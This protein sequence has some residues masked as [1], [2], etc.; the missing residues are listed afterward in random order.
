MDCV[1]Q[2]QPGISHQNHPDYALLLALGEEHLKPR[3]ATYILKPSSLS[4]LQSAPRPSRD[5]FRVK[6]LGHS[7]SLDMANV[8]RHAGTRAPDCIHQLQS[9]TGTFPSRILMAGDF[10]LCSRLWEPGASNTAEAQLFADWTQDNDLALCNTP[11]FPTHNRSR[12]ID[13]VFS[14]V[15]GTRTEVA[16]H[17]HSTTDHE[18]LF[19]R[20]PCGGENES[21]AKRSRCVYRDGDEE[22]LRE[23]YAI[24]P[25]FEV[26]PEPGFIDELATSLINNIKSAMEA[27]L[28][29]RNP[30]ARRG[31][32]WWNQECKNPLVDYKTP[33]RAGDPDRAIGG[34]QSASGRTFTAN[35]ASGCHR[36]MPKIRVP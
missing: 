19:T 12:T 1:R 27:S 11:E 32:P 36:L 9:P 17:L 33:L 3:A 26:T 14:N 10:N 30:R 5:I 18:T 20:V 8:Y 16:P 6:A 24:R 35:P 13:L 25:L 22:A 29:K 31:T 23:A 2:I 7:G 15:P 21:H 34:M 28:P 4:G